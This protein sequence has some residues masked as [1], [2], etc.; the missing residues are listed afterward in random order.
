MVWNSALFIDSSSFTSPGKW[1]HRVSF[2]SNDFGIVIW[3]DFIET[4][5]IRLKASQTWLFD[6]AST[7]S[8]HFNNSPNSW[9]DLTAFPAILPCFT[10][11]R[12]SRRKFVRFEKSAKVFPKRKKA[13]AIQ[14][15][16]S[17]DLQTAHAYCKHRI[18]DGVNRRSLG[19][20]PRTWSQ[21]ISFHEGAQA[22]W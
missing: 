14:D 13:P 8:P 6:S 15:I 17:A 2:A 1:N 7:L 20:D 19:L 11:G 18:K 12:V 16:F 4:L 9:I 21:F 22:C 10:C 3:L 5:K